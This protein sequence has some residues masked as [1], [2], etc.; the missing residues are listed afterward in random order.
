MR[1]LTGNNLVQAEA[2]TKSPIWVMEIVWLNGDYNE[3]V[4]DLYFAS[5]PHSSIGANA[6]DTSKWFPFLDPLS[7]SAVSQSVD[8]VSG[9][10][11]IGSMGFSLIDRNG[12]VSQAIRDGDTAGYGLNRQRC[13]LYLTYPGDDWADRQYMRRMQITAADTDGGSIKISSADIQRALKK[14]IFE[15][16]TD[17]LSADVLAADSA[18]ALQDA[19]SFNV[20]TH[21]S[22]TFAYV[23]IND[24]IIKYTSKTANQISG[25]VRGQQGTIATAHAQDDDVSEIIYFN[26]NPLSIALRVMKGSDIPDHWQLKMDATNHIDQ[27][28]WNSEGA[29]LCGYDPTDATAGMQ[30]EFV[31]NKDTDGKKWIEQEIMRVLGAFMP[32]RGDGRLGLRGYSDISQAESVIGVD[33]TSGAQ[34]PVID[35]DVAVKW[36]RLK[37]LSSGDLTTTVRIEYDE[38]PKASGKFIR[39]TYLTDAGSIAKHGTGKTRKFSSSGLI[40]Q[41]VYVAQIYQ[42]F[43]RV[44][45]R[46]SRPPMRLDCTLL[47]KMAAFEVGDTVRVR[48]PIRDT[49]TGEDLNRV[50]EILKTSLI[51]KTG[52]VKVSLLA[53]PEQAV[54][55]G[56]NPPYFSDDVYQVGALQTWDGSTDL[57]LPAG[58][59]YWDGN[60]TIADG[61]TLTIA[62]TVRLFSTGTIT[63]NGII[64][65]AGNGASSTATK[66]YV[67]VGGK[68]KNGYFA[69]HTDG[70]WFGGGSSY[71]GATANGLAGSQPLHTAPPVVAVIGTAQDPVSDQVTAITGLPAALLGGK[72]GGGATL[73]YAARGV[74]GNGGAGLL[75]VGRG[76]FITTG[77]VDLSGDVGGAGNYVYVGQIPGTVSDTSGQGGAGSGGTFMALAERDANGLPNLSVFTSNINTAGGDTGAGNGQK[78]SQVIG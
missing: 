70:G 76:I 45:A 10:S 42:R 61:I 67:G 9:I 66:S 22:G 72:G 75:I 59:Y 16:A 53:Q 56:F 51:P 30:F 62:G 33:A 32:V 25:C 11:T 48:L 47:P 55:A 64:D 28:A 65:G 7:L 13:D 37:I 63:V 23:K 39:K 73:G 40:P 20:V 43:Q 34:S 21:P 58:D 17:K 69:G 29:L 4:N 52:E 35:T 46:F 8:P 27:A 19:V 15:P 31:I 50:F 44:L 71:T 38:F 36:G 68:G 60:L 78:L 3:G 57:T 49:Y 54:I 18:I 14:Q 74:G 2:I 12:L 24:E 6:P 5:A 1:Q 26:E 41:G 77:S